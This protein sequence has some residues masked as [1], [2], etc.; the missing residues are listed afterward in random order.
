[1]TNIA[2][3]AAGGA[4]GAVLR[5]ATARWVQAGLSTG[6]PAG[7]LAVNIAG[8]LLMGFAS[9]WLLE[10]SSLPPEARLFLLT[11]VL[12]GF[13]TFS[14]FSLET[15]MLVEERQLGQAAAYVGLSLVGCVGAAWIGMVAG[16]QL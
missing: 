16:R 9:I 6:F 2:A 13:T 14:A 7:T 10:R 11:G 8:S 15:M 4:I 1:M 5:Y 3:I 12:G